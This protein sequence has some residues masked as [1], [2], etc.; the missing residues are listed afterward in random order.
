MPSKFQEM[1]KVQRENRETSRAGL[2]WDKG[3]DEQL[4]SL[5]NEGDTMAEIAKFLSRTEGSVKTR[6]ILCAINKMDKEG[7]EINKAAE[8]AKI[9]EKDITEFLERKSMRED[10]KLKK[11]NK[12][13]NVTNSDIYDL[14]EKMS[15][16][17]EKLLVAK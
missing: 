8:F 11:I 4:L 5:V 3:E 7:Y 2:K 6:L 14:L 9:S 10:K 15:N 12:P 17:I 13:S 1:L 16:K